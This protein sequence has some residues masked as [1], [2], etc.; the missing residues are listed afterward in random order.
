M[1]EEIFLTYV[2]KLGKTKP[3]L[4]AMLCTNVSTLFLILGGL[5]FWQVQLTWQPWAQIQWNF[6][7]VH[8]C[9]FDC[10]VHW[11]GRR[12]ESRCYKSVLKRKWTYPRKLLNYLKDFPP[13]SKTVCILYFCICDPILLVTVCLNGFKPLIHTY[14][15]SHTCHTYT[16]TVTFKGPFDSCDYCSL[17][18]IECRPRVNDI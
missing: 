16:H 2:A 3:N 10:T 13:F 8:I 7:F 5:T 9:P 4:S 12:T 14:L 6:I 15:L 11:S 18:G 1:T 17:N